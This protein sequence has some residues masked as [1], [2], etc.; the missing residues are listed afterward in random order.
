MDQPAKRERQRKGFE[1]TFELRTIEL[2]DAVTDNRS[3]YLETLALARLTPQVGEEQLAA[4]LEARCN[5]FPVPVAKKVRR[6]QA[7]LGVRAAWEASEAVIL[8]V[9]P[10]RSSY[11]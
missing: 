10:Q 7:I 9:D 6:I 5:A 3:E 1:V 8:F 4:K 2:L 11:P